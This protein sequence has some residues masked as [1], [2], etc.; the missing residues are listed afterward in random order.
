[1]S[2]MGCE[3]VSRFGDVGEVLELLRLNRWQSC[4]H[5]GG[6][7]WGRELSADRARFDNFHLTGVMQIDLRPASAPPYTFVEDNGP[8]ADSETGASKCPSSIA[9]ERFVKLIPVRCID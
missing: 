9:A 7:Y 1:M 2:W 5:R 6:W 4:S 8:S 3:V